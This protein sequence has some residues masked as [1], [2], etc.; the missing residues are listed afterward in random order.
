[1]EAWRC[2]RSERAS[3]LVVQVKEMGFRRGPILLDS[4]SIG[5][6]KIAAHQE[7]YRSAHQDKEDK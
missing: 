4:T 7:P 1:L 2:L 5:F 3:F 6:R